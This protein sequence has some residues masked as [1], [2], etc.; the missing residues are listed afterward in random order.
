MTLA[1]SMMVTTTVAI[2]TQS[3][4][5]AL[6]TS[7]TVL[8]GTGYYLFPKFMLFKSGSELSYLL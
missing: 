8:S 1:L 6:E 2:I 3:P 4:C 7:F 5:E